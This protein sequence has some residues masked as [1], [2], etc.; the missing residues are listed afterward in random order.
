MPFQYV[1]LVQ[2]ISAATPGSDAVCKLA[3]TSLYD[4]IQRHRKLNMLRS[5]QAYE[6]GTLGAPY[7]NRSYSERM[8]NGYNPGAVT[9]RQRYI[10]WRACPDNGA[11]LAAVY[12]YPCL[13]LLTQPKNENAI[14]YN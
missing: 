2:S 3:S 5:F 10:A 14:L 12:V 8:W 1:R 4:Q 11:L 6:T 7:W 13:S 9:D